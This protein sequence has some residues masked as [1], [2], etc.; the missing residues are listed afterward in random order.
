MTNPHLLCS[1]SILLA[2]K[3]AKG[4]TPNDYFDVADEHSIAKYNSLIS[5]KWASPLKRKKKME[6]LNKISYALNCF[7]HFTVC[8][9]IIQMENSYKATT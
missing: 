6:Q 1:E 3:L 9:I 2:F 7:V 4:N 8:D 5:Q